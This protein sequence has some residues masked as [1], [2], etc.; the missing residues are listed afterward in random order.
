MTQFDASAYLTFTRKDWSSFRQ[1]MPLT[2]SEADLTDLHGQMEMVSLREIEEIYLPLTRL[3]SMYVRAS[4]GLHRVS[5]DFIGRPEPKVPYIIGVSGS[6]AVGKSTTSRVLKA[7]LS[8]QSDHPK[9]SVVTTDGFL[10]PN[11]VLAAQ[12]LMDKKGFPESYDR[13]GLLQFLYDVK[14]GKTDVTAP[15]YSHHQYDIVSDEKIV[16]NRPDILILEG[17][18]IL[19]TGQQNPKEKETLFVSDFLD[20]SIFVDSDTDIIKQ[21][22]VARVKQF[23]QTAFQDP[24]AYFHF[25]T[26]MP[27]NELGKFAANVW[28]TVN[29]VNLVQNILP[30]RDRAQLILKKGP[31]H[32]VEQVKLRKL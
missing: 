27:E 16:L 31:N 25:I 22:Y 32:Q 13:A 21:W 19:Q 8:R 20:F 15:V 6:V 26:K 11:A 18:N 23:A 2:L 5:S 3:L 14:S 4:Q 7:L 1:D 30:Y 24:N 29:A 10:Y 12:G 28:E 9:V 17:V